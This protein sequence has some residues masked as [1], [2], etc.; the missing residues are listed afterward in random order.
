MSDS[1]PRIKYDQSFK[2]QGLKYI[3]DNKQ[4]N[5]IPTLKGFAELLG[6]DEESIIAW[7]NKKRKDEQGNL[8]DQLARPQFLAVVNQ[9]KDL[10]SK[11]PKIE[12]DKKGKITKG[13]AQD[14]NKNGTAGRPTKYDPKYADELLEFFSIDPNYEK[15]LDHYDKGEV[16]WTDYKKMA[17]KLPTLIDFAKKIG[18]HDDTLEDWSKAKNEDNTPKHPEFVRAYARAKELQKWFIIE[19]GLNGLY[20]PQFAIFVAKNITDMKD[21]VEADLTS[22]GEVIG[23]IVG[24]KVL[25]PKIDDTADRTND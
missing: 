7:A 19:N 21:K 16:K 8:T 13:V 2:D 22:K 25:P 14:T 24:F 11:A 18:V 3:E 12:R 15:E 4:K 10:E 23:Q 6:T 20:N 17:N 9:I 1:A 5:T